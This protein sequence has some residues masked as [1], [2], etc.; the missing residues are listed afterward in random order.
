MT[1]LV[2]V[3]M[4]CSATSLEPNVDPDTH[5]WKSINVCINDAETRTYDH[6]INTMPFGCFRNMDTSKCHFD[7]E[8]SMAIRG[9]HYDSSV[10]VAMKFKHRWWEQDK[11]QIGG[12]SSTD[13]PT[14]TVVYPSYGIGTDAATMIVS[15][16]WAQDAARFGA[17]CQGKDTPAEKRLIQLIL[18]DLSDMH[19]YPDTSTLTDLLVDYHAWN[20]YGNE[21]SSGEWLRNGSRV[22]AYMARQVHSPSLAPDSLRTCTRTSRNPLVACFTLQAKRLAYIT[23]KSSTNP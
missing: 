23:R 19:G 14:R 12:V 20:W 15:Y 8:L 11:G 10:K 13:R 22:V 1:K 5:Q 6:V 2:D 3:K 21:Y 18:K 17:L 9:L 16:T 4:G 7:W